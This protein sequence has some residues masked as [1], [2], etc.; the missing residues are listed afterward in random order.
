M[1][2]IKD[3][4][5]ILS[6]LDLV[7]RKKSQSKTDL[8]VGEVRQHQRPVGRLLSTHVFHLTSAACSLSHSSFASLDPI[9]ES[10]SFPQCAGKDVKALVDTGC[11]YNLISSACV[12][13][14]G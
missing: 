5:G 4:M 1:K 12:D 7:S 14:L 2:P 6:A 11:Q 10:I 8:A 13:R 9:K 3:F